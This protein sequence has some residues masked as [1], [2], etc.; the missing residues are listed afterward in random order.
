MTKLLEDVNE[1]ISHIQS[2]H[3]KNVILSF[4]SFLHSHV[5]MTYQDY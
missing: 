3:Y 2:K 1:E 4:V 5:P